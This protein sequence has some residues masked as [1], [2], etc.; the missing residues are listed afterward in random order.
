MEEKDFRLAELREQFRS[1]LNMLSAFEQQYT[2]VHARLEALYEREGITPPSRP[3]SAR[4]SATPSGLGAAAAGAGVGGGLGGI[5]GTGFSSRPTTGGS[6]LRP[7]SAGSAARSVRSS[8]GRLPAAVAP[9]A[10]AAFR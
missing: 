5:S 6:E 9:R 3:V 8:G 1:T 7:E 2:E 10:T 4:S